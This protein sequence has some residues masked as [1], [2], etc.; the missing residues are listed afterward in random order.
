[1]R[2]L[3]EG[4]QGAIVE[5]LQW[6]LRR[7]GA[8]LRVDG[9]FGPETLRALL[10]FQAGMNLEPDGVVGPLTWA[11][12]TGRYSR[13]VVPTRLRWSSDLLDLVLEGLRARYP[14]LR[15]SAIGSSALGRPLWQVTIG[16][17]PLRVG[18][19]AAHHA[20]EWITTPVL[21]QFL[22]QFA[23]GCALGGPLGG[24][25]CRMLYANYTLDIVPM[26][27]PD[28]VDLVTE[29]LDETSDA[30]RGAVEIAAGFPAI[31]FPEGWKA[32]IQGIDLNLAYPARWEEA[33]EIKYAQGFD[34][35]APR[36]FVG[37]APL[38]PPESRAMYERALAADYRLVLAYHTQGRLIYWTFDGLNPPGGYAL[39]KRM[40]AVS[41][42]RAE[43]TPPYSANA[44][45]KDWFIQYY[46]RPGYTIEAGEGR[47]PLPLR[48]FEEIYRDNLGILLLGMTGL[49]K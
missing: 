10:R 14:F 28:G 49:E 36:D 13:A 5:L 43:V 41:G 23:Q 38:A 4:D 27:N 16:Q 34:R 22:E 18:Y 31:P 25:D 17:G 8:R 24:A 12:L 42:Y 39:A 47:N 20:N 2:T 7:T 37:P 33:R 1:M 9:I 35:P 15:M 21:L 26:V 45:Y 29:A 44:G 30:Y 46:D 11:A 48:Q 32:N 6:G 3:T 19:N 40:E